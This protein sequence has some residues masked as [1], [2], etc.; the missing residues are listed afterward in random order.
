MSMSDPISD[1]LTRIRNA[2]KV[3]KKIVFIP[4]SKVKFSIIKIFKDEGYIKDFV[5]L[6]IVKIK[7]I[8]IFLKYYNNK[9]VIEILKR[10]SKPSLR[11]YKKKNV[12]PKILN[13]LGTVIIS[14]P[15]GIISDKKA[16]FYGVGGEIICYIA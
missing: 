2:Q 11:I 15:L 12:I 1:M 16:E 6:N 3:K 9:P 7:N 5:S 10:I 4:F 8:K 14:T 13:G